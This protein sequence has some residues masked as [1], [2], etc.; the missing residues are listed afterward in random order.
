[1]SAPHIEYILNIAHI[2]VDG[3]RRRPVG[4]VWHELPTGEVYVP[5]AAGGGLRLHFADARRLRRSFGATIRKV[6]DSA[7]LG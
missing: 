5:C 4:K 3:T 6:A 1:M 7:V 2:E